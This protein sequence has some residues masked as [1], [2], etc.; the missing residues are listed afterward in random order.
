[1]LNIFV[2]I[3]YANLKIVYNLWLRYK[4]KKNIICQQKDGLEYVQWHGHR[5]WVANWNNLNPLT[6]WVIL[7]ITHLYFS[8]IF[9]N[10]FL[11]ICDYLFKGEEKKL[12]ILDKYRDYFKLGLI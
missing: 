3:Y 5:L 7:L 4:N 11:G 9:S 6:F 8:L 12:F 1:M 2:L 10:F